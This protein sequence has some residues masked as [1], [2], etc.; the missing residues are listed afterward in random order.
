MS[1]RGRGS[2]SAN[3]PFR[4]RYSNAQGTLVRFE[5]HNRFSLS[6]AP[7]PEVSRFLGI[8]VGMFYNEHG[9]PHFHAVYGEHEVSVEVESGA[10]HG[11]FPPRAQRHVLEWAVLRKAE[12]LE[13]WDLARKG[14]PLKRIARLE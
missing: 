1:L 12:L 10:V 8:V 11:H 3:V 7:M 4:Y 9:V 13:D 5:R 6:T 14:E 2:C